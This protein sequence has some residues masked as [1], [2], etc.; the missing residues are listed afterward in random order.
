M[1]PTYGNATVSGFVGSVVSTIATPFA[2]PTIAYC[3]SSVA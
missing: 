1:Q 3:A 2:A